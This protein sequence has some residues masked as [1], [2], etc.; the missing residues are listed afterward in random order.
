MKLKE[1]IAI[2]I[3]GVLIFFVSG[4]V[5]CSY[6]ST[7]AVNPILAVALGVIVFFAV[8]AVACTVGGSRMEKKKSTQVTR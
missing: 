6:G 8:G 7:G 2:A 5:A 4:G 3:F 1:K